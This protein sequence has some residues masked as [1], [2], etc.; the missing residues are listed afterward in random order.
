MSAGFALPEPAEESRPKS[1]PKPV[2]PSPG[3][4]V[5]LYVNMRPT[6]WPS[7]EPALDAIESIFRATML[8]KL[9]VDDARFSFRHGR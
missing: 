3:L 2:P 8:L 9:S 7:L 4:L 5:R 1:V 6:L